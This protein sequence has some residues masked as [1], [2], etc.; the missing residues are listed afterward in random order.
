MRIAVLGTGAGGRCHA[1]RLAE[2]GHQVTI[3][4]RDPSVTL[5]RT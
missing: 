4:T 3:G 1:A 2:L 5:A